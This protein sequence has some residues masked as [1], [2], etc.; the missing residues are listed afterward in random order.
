MKIVFIEPRSPNF[1]IYSHFKLPRLGCVLLAT[2]ARKQGYDAVVFVEDIS[3]IDWNVVRSAD[4]VGISTITSTAPRAYALADKIRREGIKVVMGGPHVTYLPE[5]AARH[6]D[7]VLTGEAESSFVQLLEHLEGKRDEGDVH[8][9]VRM[10]GREVIRTAPPAERVNINSNP[11]PDF[12]LI[13]GF[14]STRTVTDRRITPVQ[15]SRGCPY[16][17]SFCSV[18]GIFGRKMRY[19]STENV[20]RELMRYNRKKDHIFFYDDNFA[21]SPRRAKE[22]LL[23]MLKAGTKFQWSTQ[24]RA[25]AARDLELLEL[26]R[27]THCGQVYI[28]IESV[29]P[30]SLKEARKN[31]DLEE[32]EEML[33][34]FD[35]Y[36]ID[37]HG[38]FVLG[39]DADGPDTGKATVEFAKSARISSIQAMILTPLPGSRT[40]RELEEAGRI[41]FKDWSLY[42][43]HHVVFR[44]PTMDPQQ[45]QK[46]TIDAHRMFYSN[47][48]ILR[49]C[50]QGDMG[51]AA[52][53]VYARILQHK[54]L[55]KNDLYLKALQLL[56]PSGELEVMLDMRL[57]ATV[58]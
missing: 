36:G 38:M 53:A 20:M 28:G 57:P 18:T 8:N 50:L 30:E 29:N 3:K 17:C 48:K 24:M 47:R 49:N 42:D 35:R 32:T 6:S 21:A 23:A 55:G 43:C 37:V 1:H 27:A 11:V 54:W 56:K 14:Y 2:I 15:V 46:A 10:K 45:L 34:R 22:L 12:S 9:L 13:R 39:F 52:I 41:M 16:D 4:L 44:H 5:E 7:Y 25:D 40:Y 26:M 31:Q 51:N 58:E 19:R 33:L